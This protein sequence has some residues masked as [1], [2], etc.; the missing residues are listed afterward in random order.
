MSISL[1]Q[2][3]EPVLVLFLD[4]SRLKRHLWW[5]NSRF[6]PA[7]E[8]LGPACEGSFKIVA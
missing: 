2:K 7:F 3:P 5:F 4:Y 1:T 8:Q 6:F